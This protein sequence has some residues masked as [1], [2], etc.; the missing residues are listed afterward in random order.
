MFMPQV[1]GGRESLSTNFFGTVLRSNLS[2]L[3]L[4]AVSKKYK[5]I[6]KKYFRLRLRDCLSLN[7]LGLDIEKN[8]LSEY[9]LTHS[10]L[11]MLLKN[12]IVMN[13]LSS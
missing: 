11:I 6:K 9:P 12:A 10:A 5:L 4:P 2:E 7:A 13:L 8:T 1:N 3:L